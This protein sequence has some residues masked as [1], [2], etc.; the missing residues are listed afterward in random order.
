MAQKDTSARARSAAEDTFAI[1]DPVPIKPGDPNK[2]KSVLDYD[3]V[4]DAVDSIPSSPDNSIIELYNQAIIEYGSMKI[5]AGYIRIEFEKAEIYASGLPDSTGKMTQKPIFVEAGKTY[6][7]DEMRYNFETG[8]A[9]I[10]KVITQEGEGFLHGEKV[11]KT[12]GAA[13]FVKNAAYTTCSHEHPHFR[14]RTPKAKVIP[15]EKVVTQF[16]FLE[17]FDIPTPL[18]LPFGFFPTTDKRKSGIII[19]TYGS[20]QYRGY[21]LKNGGFYWAASDYFDLSAT[22]DVY[23]KGG[24][25]LQGQSNYK[26]RY[27]FNG[28]FNVRYNLLKYGREEFESVVP[29][30][31][32]NRSDFSV[33]WSHRQDAKANPY[34][35]FSANVNI[36][37]TQFYQITSINPDQVLQNRLNSSVS[38]SRRWAGKPYNLNVTLNHSQNNQ[39][40]DMTLTLPQVNFS[41]NRMFPF[42]SEGGIVGKKK[43]YEEIG[44]TYTANAKNQIQ[45]RMDKPLFTETV[46]RDSSRMGLQHSIPISANYKV[47]KFFVFNPSI[48]FT[49]RW[50]PNKL[51]YGFDP[52]LNRVVVTDTLN[53]FFANRDF[54]ANANL[55][56]KLYGLWRYRGFL[57]AIRHVMTPTVGLSYR[58]DFSTPF[59][60]YYQEIQ[61]DTLGNTT[62]VNPYSRGVYG[63]AGQG[64]NGAITFGIQNTLEAK[65]RSKSD[66]TGLKKIKLLERFSLN[67]SYNMAAEEFKLSTI[68]MAASSSMFDRLI[69]LNYNAT[70]DPY[71]FDEGLNTRVNE[72]AIGQGQGLFRLTSQRFTAGT[73]LDASSFKSKDKKKDKKEEEEQ[74]DP[75][76]AA[77]LG[78]TEGDIDYYRLPG[79]VDFNVPWSLNLNYNLSYTKNGAADPVVRQSMDISGDMDLTQGWKVGFRTGYDF[80]AQDFTFTSFNFYRDLHCWT[81]SCSWVPFGFQQSYMLTI[82]VKSSILQDLKLERRRGVG[83][84]Q[85]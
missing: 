28:N 62:L 39:T 85:R 79:Y 72:Y 69:T 48:N 52:E 46:F 67:G 42:K 56:T 82:R 66:S 36:A 22:G 78:I 76:Q 59:W 38:F 55:S 26:V 8:K 65:V 68:R 61:S 40:K 73:R 29:G 11:K 58:P 13:F 33:T 21:F 7:A 5:E 63:S 17:L 81:M 12:G 74:N 84:F 19:P 18:M 51:E 54:N 20:S 4:Y 44:I 53:G 70:L 80:E 9:R 43:W 60:G 1:P 49:E 47:F 37:T 35:N 3:I 24:F 57:K 64:L 71:A 45:T 6:R 41:V 10:N 15:G 23:T 27:K 14:I 77:A 31:Y 25:G 30:A 75:N 50:Y 16:A 2:K 32:D 34:Y 83:D